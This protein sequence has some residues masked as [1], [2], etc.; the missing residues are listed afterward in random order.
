[1]WDHEDTATVELVDDLIA[2]CGF[3][4]DRA[5]L[6]ARKFALAT[7]DA[8]VLTMG[9]LQQDVASYLEGYEDCLRDVAEE[10]VRAMHRDYASKMG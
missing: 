6:A 5:R 2:D 1:M 9:Q 10:A 4:F 8:L 3:D 7:L